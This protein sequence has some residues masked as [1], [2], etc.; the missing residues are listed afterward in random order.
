MVIKAKPPIATRSTSARQSQP[1]AT[2]SS[3]GRFVT[4]ET[5]SVWPEAIFASSRSTSSR[6][7]GC[8]ELPRCF[9]TWRDDERAEWGLAL[10]DLQ[11]LALLNAVEWPDRGRRPISMR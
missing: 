11:S 7:F 10:E 2:R 4:S 1:C 3:A 8:D 5:E 6:T 9:G